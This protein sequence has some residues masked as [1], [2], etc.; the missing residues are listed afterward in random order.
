[1]SAVSAATSIINMLI[2]DPDLHA[3]LV[4]MPSYLHSMTA[5][6]C[7]FLAK[8]VMIHGDELIERTTVINYTSSL[9]QLYRSS[10]VGKWHLVRLMA[11][12]LEKMVKTMSTTGSAIL[13][14]THHDH[15]TFDTS[16]HSFPDL[17]GMGLPDDASLNLDPNFIL[18]DYTLGASQLMSLSNGP[19]A[20]DTSDLSPS[21]L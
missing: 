11:N 17:G 6:A 4:G 7:M 19:T 3:A 5:F 15:L 1:M 2:T 8:L 16:P 21:Y 13:G 20:F 18:A 14:H 12:G 10:P 9:I